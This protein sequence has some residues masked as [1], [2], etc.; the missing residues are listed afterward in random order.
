MITKMFLRGLALITA[1]SLW[2][3]ASNVFAASPTGQTFATPRDAVAALEKAATAN[4]L[5]DLRAIFGPSFSEI[6]NPDLV[7]TTN[8][9]TAFATALRETNRL[10]ATGERRLAL[11]FGREN[12][13]FPVPLI[14]SPRGWIFD[15]EAGVEELINRRIGRNE[16]DVLEVARTYVQAQREYAGRDRDDDDVLEYAQ[17]FHS[18]PGT[19]NGLFWSPELDGTM[20]PLGPFMAEAEAAGYRKKAESERQPFHGYFFK[21]LT[22][23]GKHAPGGKYDYVI[24]GNMIGGFALVAWPAEY[25]R[26]GI[27]TF[28]VNQQGRVFEKD[29]GRSATE[30]APGMKDY[31]PDDTWS[32]SRE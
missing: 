14:E 2:H 18:A 21:I 6:A 23:Q 1:F 10:V 30:D 26:T 28:I 11:E 12:T 25:G 29:L 5:P 9:V 3:D 13:E 24:N 17:K 31:D 22:R 27:M 7:Q 15:T 20:S 16:L 32:V 4:S 8:E 19:K